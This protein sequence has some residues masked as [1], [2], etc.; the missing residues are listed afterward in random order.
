MTLGLVCHLQRVEFFHSMSYFVNI[1][2]AHHVGMNLS[3]LQID[4]ISYNNA[5]KSVLPVDALV[6]KDSEVVSRFSRKIPRLSSCRISCERG[7]CHYNS[8]EFDYMR[9]D[10]PV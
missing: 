8:E 5:C 4:S 10:L 2:S 1:L 3:G 6:E 7:I 9:E